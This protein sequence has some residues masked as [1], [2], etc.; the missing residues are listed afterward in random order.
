MA[1]SKGDDIITL[2]SASR[3]STLKDSLKAIEV[4]L[5]ADDIQRIESIVNRTAIYVY[6]CCITFSIA[7]YQAFKLL[8]YIERNNAFSEL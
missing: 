5:S 4:N 6:G 8:T 1:L 7:L 2:V 3:R